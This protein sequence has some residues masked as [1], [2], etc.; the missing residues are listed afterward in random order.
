VYVAAVL[1]SISFTN[2][3]LVIGGPARG[4]FMEKLFLGP[5]VSDVTTSSVNYSSKPEGLEAE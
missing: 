5:A 3:A 2:V 1:G 4:W